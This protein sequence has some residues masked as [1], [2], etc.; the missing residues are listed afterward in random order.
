[1]WQNVAEDDIFGNAKRSMFEYRPKYSSSLSRCQI[2]FSIYL[3][4]A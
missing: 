1:M 3:R 4:C 2:V